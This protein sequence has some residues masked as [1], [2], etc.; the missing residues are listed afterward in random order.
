[1]LPFA[2]MSSFIRTNSRNLSEFTSPINKLITIP[3]FLSVGLLILL[4]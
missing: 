1:M 2:I 4:I 3:V